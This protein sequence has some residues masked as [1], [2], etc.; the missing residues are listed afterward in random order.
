MEKPGEENQRKVIAL[1]GKGGTGKTTLTAIMAKLLAQKGCHL[2]A[3]D[4]DPPISLTYALGAEPKNT[5]GEL[6]K[7]LIEDPREK[8]EIGDRHI[9]EVIRQEAVIHLGGVDLL[10][11]GQAEG[12]GCFCGVNELLKFGIESLAQQYDITLID[13]EAGIEQINRRVISRLDTLLLVSDATL[14]G[15]RTAVYLRDIAEKH[16]VEKEYRVGLVLNRVPGGAADLQEQAQALGLDLL[17]LIPTDDRVAEFDRL[18]RPTV[19]LPEDSPSVLAVRDLLTR[20][21]LPAG[22]RT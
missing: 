21:D 18:G 17:G 6:R 9:R 19:L 22:S 10:I 7:R 5:L 2:L 16:G 1:A 14:K 13:C 20:L 4:A 15:L 12:P 3:V 8:R 11:L